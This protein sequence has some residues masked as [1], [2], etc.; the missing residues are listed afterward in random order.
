MSVSRN[1][2]VLIIGAG[3]AGLSA[4]N[5]L[6]QSGYNVLVVDK[7][8]GLG[9]R[10]AGRRIGEATFDH[11]AQFMTARGA[12][13]KAVVAD[14][15]QAGV[16]EEWYRSY[17]GQ[18]N[19]HPRYRG[20]PTMT[21]IAKY[22][23]IGITVM[24][25]TKVSS[26]SQQGKRW[27]A[28][29][30]N[31]ETVIAKKIMITSPIP[32]TLDLLATGNIVLPADKQTR[33]NRIQYEACI[34]VM[35]V[36]DGPTAIEA[37]GAIALETGSVSWL[38]DNLQKGVS[39]IPAVTIHGSADFSAQHFE[40]DR[41]E[42]GQR[43]IDLATPFLGTAKVT[44]YQVHGW[45]YSKPTVVDDAPCMLASEATDLPP[46]ALAGDAF[47][48]PRFEGAVQSGWAA[49]NMLMGTH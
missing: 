26:I 7:G 2:D 1:T 49:A 46:L 42:A 32:Q 22:L 34:A 5:D 16:A 36:L 20:V 15:I 4:A 14:W 40:R 23:A 37:P 9:G 10:L 19:G 6:T 47:A 8:R 13:F 24:R 28:T 35:A 21:A 43:L 27:L 18:P 38:S 39:K 30:D 3:L 11:G 31:G 44:E 45:R 48:G 25:G 33:L 41:M 12:R 17:P 29:L